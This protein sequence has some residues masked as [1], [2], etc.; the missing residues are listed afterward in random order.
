MKKYNFFGSQVIFIVGLSLG[1]ITNLSSSVYGN[2]N[3]TIQ[4]T[5]KH[6][7][8]Q[9]L[10]QQTAETQTVTAILEN[11]TRFGKSVKCS[12]ILRSKKD[13][14]LDVRCSQYRS[15]L[16]LYT[17]SRLFDSSGNILQCS[18]VQA[19][20]Q[21]NA[22]SIRIRFPQDTPVK[23]IF[24]FSDVPDSSNVMDTFEIHL[25]DKFLKFRNINFS[26]GSK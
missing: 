16:S 14:Y 11:C 1:I 21:N 15:G 10:A 22:L 20:N 12:V 6:K 8:P 9:L 17:G 13:Q 7:Q 19:G 24:T 23:A 5:E 2:N 18:D 26:G 3:T 4:Y 25:D